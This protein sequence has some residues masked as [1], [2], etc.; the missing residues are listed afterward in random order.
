MKRIAIPKTEWNER[1]TQLL[2]SHEIYAP[3]ENE[4]SLDY[5]RL[6]SETF[7]PP[8][9]G[10]CYIIGTALSQSIDPWHSQL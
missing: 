10:E 3:L 4:Y 8:R 9:E 1:L 7:L 2:S 6:T 5:A